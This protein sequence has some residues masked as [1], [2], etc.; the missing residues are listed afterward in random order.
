LRPDSQ[1]SLRSGGHPRPVRRLP[2]LA[3]LLACLGFASTASAA[4]QFR[5]AILSTNTPRS[6]QATAEWGGP[7]VA[8]DGEMVTIYFSSS[9]PVDP[10]R[11]TQWADFMTS[12]VHG[13]ELATVAIHL[14]PLTE[15]QRVCGGRALACYFPNSGTIY[16]P[17]E[18]PALDVFAKGILAHEFGHHIAANRTNPPFDSIDYGTKRWASY[19]DV[20]AGTLAGDLY[21]GAE[22]STHYM[23]N[24]GEAFAE[25]Y[26]LL[27][28]QR[29]GL[30]QESWD[31]V[32]TSLYPDA[33]ALSLLEQDV[34][35]PWVTDT[36]Q[37]VT[38]KLSAKVR[39][40][41]F[42][43]STPYDGTLGI[44]PRQSGGAKVSVSLLSSGSTVKSSAFTRLSGKSLSTTVCGQRSY[45]VRVTLPSPVKKTTKTTV[46]LTVS[47]P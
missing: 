44:V 38:A 24:P 43:V 14:A 37:Q 27:N 46:R 6:L 4:P 25:S 21:P 31:I 18:D 26:R 7:T 41:T 39:T 19:E 5:D 2:F 40:R 29:L 9:Y 45:K 35:T 36:T 10:A 8:T 13:P 15:V 32:T 3:A 22:D 20:C 47:T 30:P 12:L 16:A 28:E 33:T 23:L 34:L 17:G 42:K 1:L 11:A